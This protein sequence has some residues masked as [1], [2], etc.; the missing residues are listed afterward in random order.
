[1]LKLKVSAM[2]I[3]HSQSFTGARTNKVTDEKIYNTLT[4]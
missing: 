1:M 4:I 3:K 2:E